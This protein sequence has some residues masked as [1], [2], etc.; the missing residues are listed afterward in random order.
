M[1]QTFGV[2][3]LHEEREDTWINTGQPDAIFN[4]FFEP[5]GRVKCSSEVGRVRGKKLSMDMEG[6]DRV[7]GVDLDTL[8][9]MVFAATDDDGS[10]RCVYSPVS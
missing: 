8:C 6:L 10:G 2:D 9:W 4:R 3:P 7:P 5:G 1:R